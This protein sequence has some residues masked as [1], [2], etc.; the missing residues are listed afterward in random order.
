MV[1]VM[2]NMNRDD[3][4]DS[5]DEAPTDPGDETDYAPDDPDYF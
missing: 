3:T 5:D 1:T 4:R 2:V